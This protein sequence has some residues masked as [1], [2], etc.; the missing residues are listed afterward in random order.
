M[1]YMLLANGFEEVE[2][3]AP[4]DMLR[5]AKLNV[6]TVSIEDSRE[7][8]GAHGVSVIADIMPADAGDSIDMLIF[9]GGMPG[10]SR[11]DA[12]AVTDAMIERARC[13]GARFAAICAAP[14]VLGKRGL[15]RGKRATCYPG[16]EEYLE[17]AVMEDASVV[18]DG[19]VTTAVGMGAALAFGAELVSLFSGRDASDAILSAVQAKK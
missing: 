11:L 4:L 2:A 16:F 9:P 12:S 10:S 8:C 14:L 3:L 5:R 13:D 6:K 19:N 15:L 18:T 1:I 7:V 17:G